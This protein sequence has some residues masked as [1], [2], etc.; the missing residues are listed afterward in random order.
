M[1]S[2]HPAGL[3]LAMLP[4]R[5]HSADAPLQS[6]T[7]RASNAAWQWRDCTAYRQSRVA[8][9]L[10]NKAPANAWRGGIAT[11]E[12]RSETAHPRWQLV[13]GLVAQWRR[14]GEPSLA[15]K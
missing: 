5:A 2:R 8:A 6:H 12:R 10:A 7:H 13:A 15:G 3:S 9:P 14:V 4:G 1:K 11:D